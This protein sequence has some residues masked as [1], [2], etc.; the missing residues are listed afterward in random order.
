MK[1]YL[2]VLFAILGVNYASS[3]SFSKIDSVVIKKV[4][5]N[6][7]TD[8]NISCQY[9]EEDTDCR[10]YCLKNR[11][12]IDSIC[13]E[14]E[15]LEPCKG[16]VLNVRCKL[17]FYSA[18]SLQFTL[19]VDPARCLKFGYLYKTSSHLIE[20][21][22]CCTDSILPLMDQTEVKNRTKIPYL[23]GRDSLNKFLLAQ[24]DMILKYVSN[25]LSLL[26]LCKI[27][28]DGNTKEVKIKN[29]SGLSCILSKELED[30]LRQ[31]FMNEIKWIPN[32]ERFPYEL[33]F[34]PI[35][36]KRQRVINSWDLSP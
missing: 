14:V 19:C 27:D 9:F 31:I 8:I 13:G 26:V 15:K 5:W 4:S 16:N 10:V 25:D 2:F 36:F 22:D 20:I 3:Q 1:Y 18:D 6:L 11:S 17:Y 34:I 23:G 21:I 28:K 33:V 12:I 35:K 29:D 30:F 24:K 7:M 32:I